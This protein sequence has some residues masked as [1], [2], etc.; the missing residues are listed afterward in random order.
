MNFDLSEERQML[1]DSISKFLQN[2]Y[3]FEVRRKLAKSELGFSRDNWKTYADLGWLSVPFSA[4]YGGF[5]GTTIDLMLMHEQFGKA[6][7]VE[8]LVP[9]L[10]LGGRLI[11]LLGNAE[12]KETLLSAVIQGELQLALA[13]NERIARN[14]PAVVGTTAQQAGDDYV[15]NGEKVVVLNGHAADKL[16][17]TA[18]TA[19]AVDARDGISVFLVDANAAGVERTAYPTVDGLRAADIRLNDVKVPASSLL[20]SAGAAIEALETVLDEATLA[21][22]AEAVGAMEVMY[23][24]TVEYGK[25]RKQFGLPIGKFQA[26]QF[27]MV[28]MFIAHEQSKSMIY[29]AALRAL[30]GREAARKAVSAAKVQIGK[31]SRKVGQEAVQIH[32]GMGMTDELNVGYYFKRVTAVDALLGNVDYHLAR[33]TQVA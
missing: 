33:Y 20:G 5:G 31:A 22:C 11:E 28:D 1:V 16:L 21:L 9:T 19:G 4:D 17:V 30:E 32:G 3:D 24:T 26:L 27:R 12:Q 14:N 10:I 6:M 18:R 23:K 2:D 8:P 13:S 15:L 29:M 25:T 7:V